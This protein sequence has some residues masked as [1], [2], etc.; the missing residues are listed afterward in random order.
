[1]KPYNDMSFYSRKY[2]TFPNFYLL[3]FWSNSNFDTTKYLLSHQ[4]KN[5]L[6]PRRMCSLETIWA[7][8]DLLAR[9][10]CK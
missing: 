2:G 10:V 1:M 8:F 9:H 5:Q 7:G 3:L 4:L 6:L